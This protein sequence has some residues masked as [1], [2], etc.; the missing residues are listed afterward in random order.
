M[1]P[2]STARRYA[3]AA[4][5]VAVQA[6]T[7][8]RWIADLRRAVQALSERGAA[9]YFR[10]PN[11]SREGKLGTID[12]A[13]ADLQPQAVNLLK[14]LASRSRVGLLP[15]VLYEFEELVRKGKGIAEVRVTVARELTEAERADVQRRLAAATGK[16]VDM[17]TDVDP[18]ILGGIVIRM[19]DRLIDASVAGRLER[20][21][22][23]LAV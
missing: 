2:S 9:D 7:A 8:D 21:R 19:G 11:V 6:G 5:Q 3:E 20:L 12:A 18:S 22:Q 4:Y 15:S 13:F 17:T 10:D 1:R 16:Q 23:N 14:I